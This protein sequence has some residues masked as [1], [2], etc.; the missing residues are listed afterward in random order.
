[1]HKTK[2]RML[3]WTAICANDVIRMSSVTCGVAVTWAEMQHGLSMAQVSITIKHH[4]NLDSKS[5]SSINTF[6]ST[7]TIFQKTPCSNRMEWTGMSSLSFRPFVRNDPGT[8]SLWDALLLWQVILPLCWAQRQMF[9]WFWVLSTCRPQLNPSPPQILDS[10]C[11]VQQLSCLTTTASHFVVATVSQ[12]AL[13]TNLLGLH[14]QVLHIREICEMFYYNLWCSPDPCQVQKLSMHPPPAFSRSIKN[15]KAIA[16]TSR[17]QLYT[18]SIQIVL[19]VIR[20]YK[21]LLL[22]IN[23]K[24][25]VISTQANG[26]ALELRWQAAQIS[27]GGWSRLASSDSLPLV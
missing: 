27:L 17:H 4:K 10:N 23:R 24:F 22:Q 5:L 21:C 8:R 16:C 3:L 12:C 15:L 1:M 19:S 20:P 11:T 7:P 9:V 2:K 14:L 13:E 18:P 6:F 26:P 25:I